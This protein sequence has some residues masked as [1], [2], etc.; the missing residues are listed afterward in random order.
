MKITLTS[1]IFRREIKQIN[2]LHHVQTMTNSILVTKSNKT[3]KLLHTSKLP[4]HLGF[5]WWIRGEENTWSR[6]WY[7]KSDYGDIY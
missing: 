2:T 3:L 7:Y 4:R 6:S 1:Y 5:Y